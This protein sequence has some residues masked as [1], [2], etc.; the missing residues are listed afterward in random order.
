M[1]VTTEI[2][3]SVPGIP[4]SMW[5]KSLLKKWLRR[6]SAT[7]Q[8]QLWRDCKWSS[9]IQ[10]RTELR[11]LDSHV[12]YITSFVQVY[13]DLVVFLKP[14]L[15]YSAIRC[16]DTWCNLSTYMYIHTYL[17]IYMNE[18]VNEVIKILFVELSNCGER[19]DS[20]KNAVAKT[21]YSGRRFLKRPRKSFNKKVLSFQVL[22]H[23]KSWT[24]ILP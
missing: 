2:W 17:H 13:L 21:I 19:D 8:Y 22:S 5:K 14:L 18:H 9:R 7:E 3:I 10:N 20:L 16:V 15:I 24:C 23:W 1:F 12:I 4:S 11:N 6:V